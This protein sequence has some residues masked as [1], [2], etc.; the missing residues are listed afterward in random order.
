MFSK[1]IPRHILLLGGLAVIVCLNITTPGIVAH[2]AKKGKIKAANAEGGTVAFGVNPPFVEL[3][4]KPG[5]TVSTTIR[6]FN[7]SD[8]P[9]DFVIEP[10]GLVVGK[11]N[12]V[13]RP[14]GTLPITNLA[15]PNNIVL[16]YTQ[17]EIAPHTKNDLGVN[18]TIPPSLKGT[19]YVSVRVSMSPKRPVDL[20]RPQENSKKIG[21]SFLPSMSMTIKVHVLGTLKRAYIL[22][23][24]TVEPRDGN[25]PTQASVVLHN[26]GNAEQTFHPMLILIN[27]ADKSQV[28][29][30]AAKKRAISYPGAKTRIRFKPY[31]RDVPRGR[32]TAV[33]DAGNPEVTPRSVKTKVKVAGA[34]HW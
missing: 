1:Q 6:L 4:G 3:E 23:S 18:I 21:M 25:K 34:R 19:N 22:K 17:L 29:R 28:F 26:T 5:E 8:V 33:F 24:V 10:E 11:A 32:Y 2:A 31:F 13:D 30:M 14:I 12:L 20:S 9:G 7:N 16:E 15:H 27:D